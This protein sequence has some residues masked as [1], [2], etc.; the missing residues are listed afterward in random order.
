MKTE[1]FDLFARLA[2]TR[3]GLHLT[4]DQAFLVEVRLMPV[5]RKWNCRLLD[6]LGDALRAD[7]EEALAFDIVEA[8][9]PAD[10]GF[11]FDQPLA[12]ELRASGKKRVWC[13]AAGTGQE[14]LSLALLLPNAEIVASDVSRSAITRA[15]GGLYTQFEAQR[16]L[17]A[18]LMIQHFTLVKAPGGDRWLASE[19]LRNRVQWREANLIQLI[20]PQLGALAA[21]F[22]LIL[23]R[24]VL[25]TMT[26]EA[27]VIA[28]ANVEGL[29]APGGTLIA[30]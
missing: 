25:A 17:P 6:D 27:A 24:G 14:A 22:D 26:P 29:L 12:N 3:T 8:L 9:L 13:A 19:A 20:G 16:G 4:P 5:A 7:R 28:R 15:R 1:D 21:P 30:D 10:T 2:R 18:K 23:C 11:L